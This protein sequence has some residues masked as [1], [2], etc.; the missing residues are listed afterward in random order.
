[1]NA[2]PKPLIKG[3]TI[4]LSADDAMMASMVA[5]LRMLRVH[6]KGRTLDHGELLNTR[7]WRQRWADQLHGTMAELALSRLLHLEWTPGGMDISKGDVAGT[8]EVRAT[9]HQNGHLVCFRN[10]P[11][12][13]LLCLMV[14][15]YPTFRCA[16]FMPVRAARIDE[17]WRPHEKPQ[18]WWVPQGALFDFNPRDIEP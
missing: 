4:T 12:S 16:G 8:I 17:W 2:D 9:E 5:V 15:F 3:A 13:G 10:D 1:M 7:S 6:A 18:G 14:G 11:P